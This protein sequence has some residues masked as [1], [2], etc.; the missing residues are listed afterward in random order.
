MLPDGPAIRSDRCQ[1]RQNHA[2][3]A[4]RLDQAHRRPFGRNHSR[5]CM[6]PALRID[7]LLRRLRR[8]TLA[9]DGECHSSISHLLLCEHGKLGT[10]RLFARLV[11]SARE[12]Q[13][14]S[15]EVARVQV[16]CTANPGRVPAWTDFRVGLSISATIGAFA[17]AYANGDPGIAF[18]TQLLLAGYG[19]LGPS[20]TVDPSYP[21]PLDCRCA[22]PTFIDP[23]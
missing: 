4:V 9:G 11:Q 16:H 6:L 21:T 14:Q 17:L 2:V 5:C 1:F 8:S 20:M 7:T 15:V 18:E 10:Y 3:D 12:Q 22:L 23:S 13:A 19:P